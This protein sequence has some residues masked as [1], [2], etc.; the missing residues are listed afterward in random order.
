MISK[1][2][3]LVST[4]TS[5][6][7]ESMISNSGTVIAGSSITTSISGVASGVGCGNTSTGVSGSVPGGFITSGRVVG[8][9]VVFI[10]AAGSV[11]VTS[12]TS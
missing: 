10:T 4:S 2:G 6:K 12:I 9:V 5:S 3:R 8:T 11:V 1:S 7:I